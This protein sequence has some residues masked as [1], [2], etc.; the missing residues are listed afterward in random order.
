MARHGIE[1][2]EV[3]TAPGSGWHSGSLWYGLGR[4]LSVTETKAGR[5]G[6]AVRLDPECLGAGALEPV[7]LYPGLDGLW[8][9]E[10]SWS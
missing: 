3:Q 8:W 10:V 9:V 6:E 1:A 2:R 4:R 7:L 5:Q